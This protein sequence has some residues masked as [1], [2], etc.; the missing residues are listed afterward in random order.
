M[1]G[2]GNSITLC[3][4]FDP[5]L[6]FSS[7]INRGFR[8]LQ[9]MPLD[10]DSLGSLRIDRSA[11][12]SDGGS[13]KRLFYIAGA[14]VLVIAL[15]A[16]LWLWLGGKTGEVN[17]VTAEADSSGP[18]MGNSVLNASGYVVARRMATVS[19]K[20]T[21]KVQEILVEEGMSVK[22]DQV[23]ARLDPVNSRTVLTMAQRQL[24]ACRRNL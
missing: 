3:A 9:G 19:A 5:R 16:G 15:A 18:S 6:D 7:R 23:L 20:V 22:K 1:S 2:P 4:C 10:S 21:G 12:V 14:L 24:G 17:T 11:P 13:R 8:D